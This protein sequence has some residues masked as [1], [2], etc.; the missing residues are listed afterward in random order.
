MYHIVVVLKYYKSTG[1]SEKG[2]PFFV[3]ASTPTQE[4]LEWRKVVIQRRK[5]RPNYVQP[6]TFNDTA[7]GS[8]KLKNYP[9]SDEGMIQS[10]VDRYS[11][12]RRFGRRALAALKAVWE[13]DQQ[14]FTTVPL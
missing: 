10:F 9:G 5:P 7:S 8:V 12:R 2:I 13:R 1:N 4:Q 14:Y 3:N 11:D 6:V